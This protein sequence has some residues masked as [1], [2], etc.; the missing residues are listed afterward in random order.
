MKTPVPQPH[1][2]IVVDDAGLTSYQGNRIVQYITEH[3]GFDPEHLAEL[4]FSHEDWRQYSQLLGKPW[5]D[6][7]MPHFPDLESDLAEQSRRVRDINVERMLGVYNLHKAEF[8]AWVFENCL[9]PNRS[10]VG[11]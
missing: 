9:S 5:K 10:P 8:V 11:E 7:Q 2:P 6:H 3:G 4:G 1:Q